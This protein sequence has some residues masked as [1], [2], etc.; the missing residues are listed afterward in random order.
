MLLLQA[1]CRYSKCVEVPSIP[2]FSYCIAP[3]IALP[4]LLPERVT[5]APLSTPLC[6]MPTLT[7]QLLFAKTAQIQWLL[8]EAV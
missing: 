1:G 4:A 5:C 6:S 3:L 2:F 8:I 7:L